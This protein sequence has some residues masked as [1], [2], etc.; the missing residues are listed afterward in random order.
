MSFLYYTLPAL[1]K[2]LK[3]II[4]T[5]VAILILWFFGRNLDWQEVER[6]PQQAESDIYRALGT[7]HLSWVFSAGDQVEGS[8][9][10]DHEKQSYSELLRPRLSDLRRFF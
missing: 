5:L 10:A 9:G 1:R 3:F 2:Y 7:D 4:L 8:A 6:E